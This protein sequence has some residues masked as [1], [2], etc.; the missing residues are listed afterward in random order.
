M[1]KNW[2]RINK[3]PD[4]TLRFLLTTT[5]DER[6]LDGLQAGFP[7]FFSP[8]EQ[9]LRV[10]LSVIKGWYEVGSDNEGLPL[11]E[12][13]MEGLGIPHFMFGSGTEVTTYPEEWKRVLKKRAIAINSP[14]Y[15]KLLYL[16]WQGKRCLVADH[17][18][19]GEMIILVPEQ[20]IDVNA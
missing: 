12:T 13:I 10:A 20:F 7:E 2:Q 5:N 18:D 15:K 17:T 16:D 9:P 4:F 1:Y 3:E 6:I 11:P 8:E 19:E 14:Q